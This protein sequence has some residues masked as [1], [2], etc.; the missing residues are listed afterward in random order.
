MS[1]IEDVGKEWEVEREKDIIDYKQLGIEPKWTLNGKLNDLPLPQPFKSRPSIGC[2]GFIKNQVRKMWP[3]LYKEI[4]D[5]SEDSRL[6][7]SSL[8]LMGVIFSEEY[9][10]QFLDAFVT[11]TIIG[12]RIG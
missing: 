8:I 7:A 3:A 9:M 2:R 1:I 5:S 12:I 10:T 6:K 11:N 4:L